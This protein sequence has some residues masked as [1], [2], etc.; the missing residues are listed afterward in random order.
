MNTVTTSLLLA[1]LLF[2]TPVFAAGPIA[3]SVERLARANGQQRDI[4]PEPSGEGMFW[5]GLAMVGAGA[6]LEILLYTALRHEECLIA[7]GL[8]ASSK[9][10]PTEE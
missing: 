3:S 5:A 6:T 8:A 10:Q 2:S 4:R 9:R 1:C 7:T